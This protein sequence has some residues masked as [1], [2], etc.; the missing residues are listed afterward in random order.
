MTMNSRREFM[1]TASAGAAT[2]ALAARTAW[3]NLLW[4]HRDS[5][6]YS[7]QAQTKTVL[8]SGW[9][10][11]DAIK[12]SASVDQMSRVSFVADSWYKA[13]VP[14]TVLTTLV[15]NGVYPE[16]LYGE[17]NR[18]DKIPETLARAD[19]W[20]RNVFV[21]PSAYSGKKIWLNFDGINY[22]AEVWVNGKSIGTVDGA[23][24]RGIFDITSLVVP[25]KQAVAVVRVFPQPHP[26][27]PSEHTMGAGNGIIGGITRIDGPTFACTIGWDWMP[28]IR[29]RDTGIW[30]KVFL[31]ATGPA[32]IK[33][34]Q[35]TTDL[36]SLRTD[37]AEVTVTATVQ[38]VTDQT[39]TCVLKGSFGNVKFEKPIK[40][41]ANTSQTVTFDPKAF[42][43][44]RLLIP[45]FGGRMVLVRKIS[46]GC[47]LLSKWRT[48]Y[49]TFKTSP[50]AS[51]KLPIKSRKPAIWR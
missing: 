31:T 37:L 4:P 19:W 13:T 36:P 40:L 30:Q 1:T 26:G 48:L 47:I 5:W 6:L 14:G 28:G 43:Q 39:Q 23:F 20:Y 24:I 17:N 49:P 42:T 38:N 15:D 10:L 35:V 41:A 50:S 34:P 9:E 12:V 25:G 46:T 7:V 33:N 8:E 32:V 22:E 27:V 29:D 16:P 45:S 51:A 44:L 18:P 11:Q 2:L 21:V 3:A